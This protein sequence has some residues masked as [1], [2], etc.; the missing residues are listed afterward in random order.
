MNTPIG[1]HAFCWRGYVIA[2]T[3]GPAMRVLHPRSTKEKGIT[4]GIRKGNGWD[5]PE[6]DEA[7]KG[8]ERALLSAF[9]AI[10]AI[11]AAAFLLT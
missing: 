8:D 9:V 11:W 4:A 5:D 7:D 3:A 1:S 2:V 6:T 10:V